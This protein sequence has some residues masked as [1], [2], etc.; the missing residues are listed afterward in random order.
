MA[1]A[2]A[3]RGGGATPRSWTWA[4]LMHRAF[5]VDVLARPHCGGRLRRIATLH[6]PAV[7]QHKRLKRG[8]RLRPLHLG[9]SKPSP[10]E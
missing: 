6:D 4:A 1:R 7:N 5:T 10:C 8:R 9:T 2:E 3:E